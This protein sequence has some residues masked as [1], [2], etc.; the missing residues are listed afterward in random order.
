MKLLVRLTILGLAAVGAKTLYDRL[1]PQV[2]G[3]TS[4]GSVVNDTLTPAFRDAAQSVRNA[5]THAAHEVA[6]ATKEA[7]HELKD[8]ATGAAPASSGQ[9]SPGAAAPAS[10]ATEGAFGAS[11]PQGSDQPLSPMAA[12][13]LG[14]DERARS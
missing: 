3:A 5:S 9:D 6:G 8:V 13:D 4:P 11:A 1:R 10:G 12:Q 14:L 7:A 2:S